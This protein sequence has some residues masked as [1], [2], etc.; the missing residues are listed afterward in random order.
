MS[1]TEPPI[2]VF[3]DGA[4]PRCVRDRA[5]D[6]PWAGPAGEWICWFDLTGQE[7]RL[8]K[9]GIDPRRALTELHGLDAHQ[10]LRS[11]LDAYILLLD[12]VPR[13]KPL[14]WLVGRPWIRPWLA[15]LYHGGVQRRL[16]RSGRLG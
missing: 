2:T 1:E 7:V 14:A 10:R 13:L 5:Q 9:L 6:E 4:G 3:Y 12:R 11:E 8:R 16:R 15:R